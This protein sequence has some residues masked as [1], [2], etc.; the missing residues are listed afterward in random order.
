MKT[1]MTIYVDSDIAALMDAEI[2]ED[3]NISRSSLI[4]DVMRKYY[5]QRIGRDS[6]YEFDE[7]ELMNQVGSITDTCHQIYRNI[8]YMNNLINGG[9]PVFRTNSEDTKVLKPTG[10][11]RKEA[12]RKMM[13]SYAKM[14]K[15]EM[16]REDYL[17]SEESDDE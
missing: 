13:I 2:K 14:L 11:L 9:L 1:Q 16:P 17:L 12:S 5:R 6:P 10:N 4:N 8:C 3:G 7:M 15:G